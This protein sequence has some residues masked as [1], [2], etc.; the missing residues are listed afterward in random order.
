[1]SEI[2]TDRVCD[3][4]CILAVGTVV[5]LAI[6][7]PYG[8][9]ILLGQVTEELAESRL[10]LLSHLWPGRHDWNVILCAVGGKK[11]KD[12]LRE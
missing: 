8:I 6:E 3:E 12:V 7:Y 1:M 2:S 4:V 10:V 5:L 9:I 11:R